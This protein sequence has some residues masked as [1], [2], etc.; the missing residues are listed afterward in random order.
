MLLSEQLP[1]AA[2]GESGGE[3]GA[4]GRA[5]SPAARPGR[6]QPR[7]GAAAPLCRAH[8]QQAGVGGRG[9]ERFPSGKGLLRTGQSISSDLVRE[10]PVRGLP[11]ERRGKRNCGRS[12]HEGGCTLHVM[13][14]RYKIYICTSSAP[15]SPPHRVRVPHTGGKRPRT[16]A[17]C[18]PR[19]KGRGPAA[20]RG[21]SAGNQHL[22]LKTWP[23]SP[24]RGVC[25][26]GGPAG[27]RAGAAAQP[28]P[29]SGSAAAV[30][31]AWPR[32]ATAGA[33]D[34]AVGTCAVCFVG[35]MH[36]TGGH[37]CRCTY[38]P[39][40]HRS[41]YRLCYKYIRICKYIYI[42]LSIFVCK[43]RVVFLERR[44]FLCLRGGV[45]LKAHVTS[46]ISCQ[47][48]C[49]MGSRLR[50]NGCIFQ[51]RPE[52][53]IIEVPILNQAQDRF[54]QLAERTKVGSVSPQRGC[55]LGRGVY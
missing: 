13:Y 21:V 15:R 45:F 29:R 48:L 55:V 23:F 41:R 24:E 8:F 52:R 6:R 17:R 9:G 50:P 20:Q 36:R 12:P 42:S 14:H 18:A 30:L 19:N 54:P 49:T 5:G 37:P 53:L 46:V 2:S 40:N 31:R 33:G 44:I 4:G 7:R 27:A 47:R 28:G 43:E 3:P 16:R 25:C 38:A 11:R 35:T 10:E 32:A 26:R 39:R 1:E 22:F 51:I 34:P